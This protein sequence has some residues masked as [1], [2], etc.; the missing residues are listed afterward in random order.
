MKT[1][2]MIKYKEGFISKIKN[3]FK[4]LFQRKEHNYE[5]TEK[6]NGEKIENIEQNE[7]LNNMQIDEK[8]ENKAIKK[9]SFLKEIEGNEELLNLLS[10][11]R[12]KKLEEYYSGIIAENEIKIKRL[13]TEQ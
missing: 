8:P 7:F 13:K 4:S 10:I 1:N 5:Q 11:G 12:L 3:F 9:D 2:E 6:K